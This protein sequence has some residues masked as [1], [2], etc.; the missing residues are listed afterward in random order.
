MN[1]D[2]RDLRELFTQLRREDR[3]RVPSFQ[4]PAPRVSRWMRAPRLAAAAAIILIAL[5]LARPDRARRNLPLQV[6]DLG[7]ATWRSPTDFLL[8][9]PGSELLRT[10][11]AVGLP[12]DW[13][14]IDLRGRSSAPESTRS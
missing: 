14:P 13:T 3:A 12:H 8:V 5:V 7:A 10:V 2:D 11:P 4:A 1:D 9:T 6:V